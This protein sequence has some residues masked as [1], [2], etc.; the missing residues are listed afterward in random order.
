MLTVHGKLMLVGLVLFT[1]LIFLIH[2]QPF[3]EATLK[4]VFI[5][6]TCAMPCFMGIQPGLTT[7]DD[8]KEALQKHVWVGKLIWKPEGNI[9]GWTW[10]GQQPAL[11]DASQT[12][13]LTPDAAGKLVDRIM[14]PTTTSVGAVSLVFGRLSEFKVAVYGYGFPPG[15][16]DVFYLTSYRDYPISVNG[17]IACPLRWLTLWRETAVITYHSLSAAS[18]MPWREQL[19]ENAW[20]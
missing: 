8:A 14:I 5:P 19:Q 3:D 9:F 11:I 1:A 20:C 17:I 4:S 13:S 10:S 12:G 6:D 2:T 7:L 18:Q 16:P 15:E